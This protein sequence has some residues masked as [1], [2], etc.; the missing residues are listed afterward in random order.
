M[1]SQ[2]FKLISNNL[3]F[4]LAPKDSDEIEQHLTVAASGRVWFS[5]RNYEQYCVE[6]G[7]CRKKQLNI[8]EWKAQFL[9]KLIRSIH[10]EYR[11]LESM[12]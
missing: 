9:I 3:S 7:F 11:K 2:S 8:G 5:T 4:G 10:V 6:K 12:A 1:E